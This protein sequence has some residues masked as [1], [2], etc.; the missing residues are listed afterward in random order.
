MRF[1]FERS[2]RIGIDV[3]ALWD[4]LAD[5]RA[6]PRWWPWL[7]DAQL[8]A[9]VAG[10][11]AVFVVAPPLPYHLHLRLALTEV[12]AGRRVAADVEGDLAGRAQLTLAPD[13]EASIATLSW[14][15]EL[16]RRGLRSL[17][18]LARPVLE[19]GHESV[20]RSG[21]RSFAA[22]LDADVR[23]IDRPV[24]LTSRARAAVPALVG[25]GIVAAVVAGAA[26]GAPSTLAALV[27]RRPLL[28]ST[29][30]AGTLFGAPTVGRGVLAHS[31]LSLGWATG[32]AAL[33]P[34]GAGI[35]ASAV[36]G[37]LVGVAIAA[38]DLGVIAPQRFPAVAALPIAAQV[39]D[40]A[41]FGALV[42]ATLAWR[43]RGFRDTPG[44]LQVKASPS[45]DDVLRG[46]AHT[47]RG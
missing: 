25:D 23:E 12:T 11:R 29:R 42:G 41:V 34:P 9:L 39:A 47:R 31:A 45:P 46:R 1:A 43:R 33:W 22:A 27:R 37:A 13:G 7:R 21:V 32:L 20:V 36:T 17:G 35:A 38:V 6:Y 3:E 16:R 30:A 44:F 26:S 8:P 18:R 40:H 10:S 19:A 28:A 24:D 5:T 4:A 15:L 2:W 14:D